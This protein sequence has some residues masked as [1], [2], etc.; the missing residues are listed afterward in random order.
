MQ[1]DILPVITHPELENICHTCGT[2]YAQESPMNCPVC[3]DERQYVPVSGQKWTSHS[4]LS[5]TKSIRFSKLL[6]DV[7]DLR[8]S[9]AFGI[10]QRAHLILSQSGNLL[11]DCLPFL[12]EATVAFIRSKGGLKGIAISHPHYYS[13]M[14]VWAETFNCPV[15]LHQ[16]DSQWVMDQ[17]DHIVFFEEG[18]QVLWDG[19]EIIHTG[20]HFAGST[21]LHVP[22]AGNEGSL[23][24]GDT[25]QISQSRLFISMMYS[26]P[27]HIPLPLKGIQHINEQL[28][29]LKFDSMYGAFEW[30]NIRTGAKEIFVRSVKRYE[31]IHH[32]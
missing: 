10:A 29:P 11:W 12:D 14:A 24:V 18:K 21:V 32:D 26:Y 28:A 2:R 23:F 20:G 3:D 25:L 1:E 13:L 9:P 6:P 7:Y 16:A 8:I 15:Y 30:Q 17:S 4:E 19:I 5:K 31:D 27:N 22:N